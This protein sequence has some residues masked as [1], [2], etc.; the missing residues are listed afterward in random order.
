VEA[1]HAALSAVSEPPALVHGDLWSGNVIADAQGKPALIDPAA[2]FAHREVDIAYTRLFGG[3]G[4]AFYAAYDEAFPLRE[5][6]AERKDLYNVYHLLNHAL[7][8]GGGYLA[9]AQ[10]VMRRFV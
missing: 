2:H 4:P 10:S 6:F 7:I 9:Q 3:F 1:A 8:F 5:G